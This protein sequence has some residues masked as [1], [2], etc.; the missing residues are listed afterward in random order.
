MAPRQVTTGVTL[1][2]LCLVLAVGAV[3]G[4]KS[5]VSPLGSAEPTAQPSP[6][7]SM[8]TVRAGQVV[9]ASEVQVSVFNAGT[10]SG[11]A[12][13]TLASLAARGVKKGEAGNA[14]SDM[15]VRVVRVFS[16]K[17]IDPGALLVAR[18]FGP[19]LEV[20]VSHRD[21]GPGVDVVVGND[22]N[23]LAK[24]EKSIKV[25]HEQTVCAPSGTKTAR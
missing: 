22:F 11:L 12:T 8:E 15:A 1:V 19:K 9:H 5:L 14:P 23:K 10:R 4:W 3:F 24:A 18:Q 16:T 25:H 21:L 13:T 2:V 7:C 20:R 17:K 6:S